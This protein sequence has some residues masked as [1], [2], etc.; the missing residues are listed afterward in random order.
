[1]KSRRPEKKR[2]EEEAPNDWYEKE[3]DSLAANW[4]KQSL[5]SEQQ[6]APATKAEEVSPV[7]ELKCKKYFERCTVAMGFGYNSK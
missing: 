1:M 3:N 5:E 7:E 2:I 6:N 4:S